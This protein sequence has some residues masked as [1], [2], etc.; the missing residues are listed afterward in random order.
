LGNK[1]RTNHELR[2]ARIRTGLTAN[3]DDTF[4]EYF[5]VEKEFENL[6]VSIQIHTDEFCMIFSAPEMLMFILPFESY[7]INTDVTY[8]AAP[9]GYYLCSS[10]IFVPPMRRNVVVFQAIIKN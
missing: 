8:K 6:V 7:P 9:I 4:E 5:K 3:Q 2:V 10:V 1:Y